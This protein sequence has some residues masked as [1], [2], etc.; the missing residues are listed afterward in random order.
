SIRNHIANVDRAMSQ[1][2]TASNRNY[3]INQRNALVNAYNAC[4][5]SHSGGGGGYS[6]GGGN[7]YQQGL[8]ALQGILG[9]V[10]DMIRQQEQ[11]EHQENNRLGREAESEGVD[12]YNSGRYEQALYAFQRGYQYFQQ[13]GEGSNMAVMQNH[14]NRTRERMERQER[15]KREQRERERQREQARRWEEQH[16]AKQGEREQAVKE[17][18]LSPVPP[19]GEGRANPSG[20]G[21]ERDDFWKNAG[22]SDEAIRRQCASTSNPGMC[23]ALYKSQRSEQRAKLAVQSDPEIARKCGKLSPTQQTICV[24]RVQQ[25]RDGFVMPDFKNLP[26]GGERNNPFGCG[27]GPHPPDVRGCYDL[28]GG[29]KPA[30]QGSDGPKAGEAGKGEGS[31]K[32]ALREA[33]LRRQ[34]ERE[35]MRRR[36]AESETGGPASTVPVNPPSGSGAGPGGPAALVPPAAAAPRVNPFEEPAPPQSQASLQPT[37]P[38]EEPLNKQ[39]LARPECRQS[40]EAY[41]AERAIAG[42]FN[43]AEELI[44]GQQ[45]YDR[46]RKLGCFSAEPKQPEQQAGPPQAAGG[47][48]PVPGRQNPF[49]Q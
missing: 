12:H 45:D 8:G 27:P 11:R 21:P 14:I 32:K 15:A 48:T 34:A 22:I 6:G 18:F 7:R 26:G 29:A 41:Q 5:Q 35:A 44:A 25:E 47:S 24:L 13:N 49:N 40:D 4:L 19:D 17:L 20:Q 3:H 30:P 2:T 16:K 28:T 31:K 42:G 10:Q 1:D 23:E 39:M 9:G 37:L 43:T 36:Q 38:S 33:V 46:R